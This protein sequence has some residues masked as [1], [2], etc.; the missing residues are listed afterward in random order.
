MKEKWNKPL[1]TIVYVENKDVM[2]FASGE[3][4]NE[5]DG[6]LGEWTDQQTSTYNVIGSVLR[7]KKGEKQSF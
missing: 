7:G 6:D 3:S 4:S 2:T 1:L 5:S